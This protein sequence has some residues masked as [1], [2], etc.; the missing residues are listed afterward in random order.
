MD[1]IKQASNWSCA[2]VLDHH[3]LG[4]TREPSPRVPWAKIAKTEPGS[5]HAHQ[6]LD[7]TLGAS[8]VLA[9]DLH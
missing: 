3:D 4:M 1:A 5:L 9:A 6:G 2:E 7:G 8:V